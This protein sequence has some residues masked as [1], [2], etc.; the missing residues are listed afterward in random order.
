MP[1]RSGPCAGG[2][3][4]E[5]ARSSARLV[6]ERFDAALQIHERWIRRDI[7]GA[8]PRPL[9][10]LESPIHAAEDVG[11]PERVEIAVSSHSP[12]QREPARRRE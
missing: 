4:L 6:L 2:V 10:A 9:D 5:R 7:Q 8:I 12:M 1:V 3:A 11:H